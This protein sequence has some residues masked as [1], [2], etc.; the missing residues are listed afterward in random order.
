MGFVTKVIWTDMGT[1]S[2]ENYVNGNT[3]NPPYPPFGG[4]E[5][6]PFYA[7]LNKMIE[8]WA[9][10]TMSQS[11]PPKRLAASGAVNY[12]YPKGTPR[13]RLVDWEVMTTNWAPGVGVDVLI[14]SISS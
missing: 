11:R 2:F 9:F 3:P 1:D 12:E 10:A 5:Y 6:M 14:Y 13:S 8:G 4:D 7:R